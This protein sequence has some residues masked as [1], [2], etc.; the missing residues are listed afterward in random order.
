[1]KCCYIQ[2]HIQTKRFISRDSSHAKGCTC[3]DVQ[4]HMCDSCRTQATTTERAKR[5]TSDCQKCVLKKTHPQ[6]LQPPCVDA[7]HSQAHSSQ[8]LHSTKTHRLCT[9]R[10]YTACSSNLTDN[11]ERIPHTHAGHI[12]QHI[13]ARAHTADC[14]RTQPYCS[15]MH[16][17][18][19]TNTCA[20][21]AANAVSSRL[22]RHAP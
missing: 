15:S 16:T 2:R 10:A 22:E 20:T 13:D 6:Q 14:T 18:V 7:P 11:M 19:C 12:R 9:Q 1:M 17:R 5:K 8:A 4:V 3:T 21:R